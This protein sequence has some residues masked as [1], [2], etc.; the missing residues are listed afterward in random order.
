MRSDAVRRGQRR[1]GHTSWLRR[2][3]D[4]PDPCPGQ[5]WLP[6]G[7]RHRGPDPGTRPSPRVICLRD[8]LVTG[9]YRDLADARLDGLS[10]G[11]GP[12]V[13]LLALEGYDDVLGE[14]LEV[15]RKLDPLEPTRTTGSRR[16][17]ITS[18]GTGVCPRNTRPAE[19]GGTGAWSERKLLNISRSGAGDQRPQ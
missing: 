19:R 7:L 1:A 8:Y 4:R 2:V 3:R 15:V 6:R 16:L 13:Q 17:E 5:P 14:C 11:R 18:S 10:V 12:V 9:T